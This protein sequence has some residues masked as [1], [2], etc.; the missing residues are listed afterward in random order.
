MCIRDRLQGHHI[1][2]DRTNNSW[3]NIAL[4]P[5]KLHQAV[6]RCDKKY[7]VPDKFEICVAP[8]EEQERR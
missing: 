2:H 8:Q 6:H 4:L 1:D 5:E 7:G 3:E